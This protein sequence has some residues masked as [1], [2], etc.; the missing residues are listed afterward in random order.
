MYVKHVV[1]D[2]GGRTV[3]TTTLRRSTVETNHRFRTPDF[4]S[5]TIA[6]EDRRAGWL[7]KLSK[8]GAGLIIF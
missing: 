3:S 7:V 4:W 1:L 6:L 5:K 8:T 2:T